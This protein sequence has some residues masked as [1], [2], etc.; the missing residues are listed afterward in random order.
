M[1]KSQVSRKFFKNALLS[2]LIDCK[3]CNTK[4]ETTRQQMERILNVIANKE[5]FWV[6]SY[7]GVS[8]SLVQW[9]LYSL[10]FKNESRFLKS[11][12]CLCLS[13]E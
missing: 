13:H 8:L 9:L 11:P 7:N 6:Y 5:T 10:L 12:V 3:F 4:H 1:N 2:C